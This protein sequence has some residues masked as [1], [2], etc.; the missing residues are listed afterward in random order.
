VV[1]RLRALIWDVDGTLAETERDGHRVAFNQAFEALGVPW[2][3]DVS[4]Y[5][6]LLATTGGY[7]RLM[8]DMQSQP[9]APLAVDERSRLAHRLHGLK[10]EAYAALVRDGRIPLRPGVRALMGDCAR[11]ALP[12]AI[13]TTTSRAN[14]DA[15]LGV[16][17]GSAWRQHF[18]AVL[19]GEDA[20]NKKPDPEVYLRTLQQLG[21]AA[22]QVVAIED[23][24]PGVAACLAAGVPVVVTRSVYFEQAMC[25]VPQALAVGPGLHTRSGW[26]TPP[27]TAEGCER[28]AQVGRSADDA[29]TADDDRVS[30]GWLRR[31][32]EHAAV[33]AAE[34]GPS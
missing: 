5:G 28:A 2:R 16:H 9:L 11:E 14:V 3:W 27:G 6:Q 12:M 25:R 24:P 23:S 20:P 19:C 22:D 29:G 34:P 1:P 8:V 30:L 31:W 21:L 33:L 26:P 32:F 18:E 15:L 7:E 13:A 17:L 4:R 10:N